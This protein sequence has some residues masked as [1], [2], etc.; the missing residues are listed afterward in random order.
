MNPIRF[1]TTFRST[2]FGVATAAGCTALVVVSCDFNVNYKNGDGNITASSIQVPPFDGIIVGGNYN[3]LLVEGHEHRVE[4]TTD[5]NLLRHIEVGDRDGLL[6]IGSLKKLRGTEGISIEAHYKTLNR[7]VIT[8][9][10]SVRTRGSIDTEL[11]VLD[12][13]GS[14]AFSGNFN[15]GRLEVNMSGAGV[16]KAMG[17]AEFQKIV[18]SGAGGYEGARL[19]CK[20]CDVT[21]S[22]IG[23]ARVYVTDTLKASITGVG[24]I[25]YR[26][27]P[28]HI[29]RRITGLG[30]VKP[31]G[32]VPENS[33]DI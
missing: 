7:V 3:V 14:A 16:V 15:T 28:V 21:L 19:Q 8:G 24:G 32:D 26:G 1:I 20:S 4:I 10:S 31:D 5:Q 6:Y 2:L 11:F 25:L 27:D 18:I 33:R 13:S 23:G 12:Q 29:K 22:G 30:K 17:Y 9:S